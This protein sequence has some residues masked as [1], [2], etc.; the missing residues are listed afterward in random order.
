MNEKAK[1]IGKKVRETVEQARKQFLG[2]EQQVK[3]K[4]REL[5]AKVVERVQSAQKQFQGVEEEVQKF[6]KN[7]QEKVLTSPGEGAKKLDEL[8]QTLAV[9]DFVEKVK[10]IEMFKQG[11]AVKKDILDRFGLADAAEVAAL[12]AGLTKV[13]QTLATLNSKFRSL[14]GKATGTAPASSEPKA[15]PKPDPKA[16]PKPEPKAEPK[17]APKVE[18]KAQPKPAAKPAPKPEL[19]LPAKKK[20]AAKKPAARKPAGKKPAGK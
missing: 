10:A 3:E 9:H 7:V 2:E 5:S 18:P 15:Q 12:K 6:V 17:P 14:L 11:Q 16:E 13:E 8:L 1:E 19:K 4:A 20:P